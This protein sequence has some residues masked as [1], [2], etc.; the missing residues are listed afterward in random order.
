MYGVMLAS[1]K[2]RYGVFSYFPEGL[3]AVLPSFCRGEVEGVR[4]ELAMGSAC[5]AVGGRAVVLE[6]GCD[7][8]P[9]SG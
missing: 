7:L 2:G 1:A 6:D 4:D 5:A 8:Q 9:D 3:A